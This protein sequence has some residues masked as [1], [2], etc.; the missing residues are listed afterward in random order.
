MTSLKSLH[1]LFQI[2]EMR[3]LIADL[4]LLRRDSPI[5]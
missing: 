2:G 1:A 5:G 4:T 3:A